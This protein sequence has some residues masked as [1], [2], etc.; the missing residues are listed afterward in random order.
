[1]SSSFS[2]PTQ[3]ASQLMDTEPGGQSSQYEGQQVIF[4]KDP[5]TVD[6]QL[7]NCGE[8]FSS[9][10]AKSQ[11]K[12][13]IDERERNE[14]KIRSGKASSLFTSEEDGGG[15]GEKTVGITGKANQGVTFGNDKK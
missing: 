4:D 8:Q 10:A 11:A 3:N 2:P 7:T 15:V 13:E 5:I 1:M 9:T 6:S 14:E 12:E